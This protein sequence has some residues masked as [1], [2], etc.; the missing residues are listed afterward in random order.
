[1]AAA[2][3]ITEVH[4]RLGPV[5]AALPDLAVVTAAFAVAAAVFGGAARASDGAGRRSRGPLRYPV[6][7]KPFRAPARVVVH[8][9]RPQGF[10]AVL[11]RVVQNFVDR[12]G[13]AGRVLSAVTVHGLRWSVYWLWAALVTCVNW[14]VRWIRHA[15]EIVVEGLK[16]MWQAARQA[17]RT[18]A[19]P[20]AGALVGARLAFLFA[21]N[22]REYLFSGSLAA[23]GM[24]ALYGGA[25]VTALT[26]AWISIGRHRWGQSLRS[27]GR[28]LSIYIANGVLWQAVGGWA[29]G[30]FGTFGPGPIRIGWL[31]WAAT[32][33]LVAT[34]LWSYRKGRHAEST[35][36]QVSGLVP[37]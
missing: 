23:L 7:P 18:V 13:W 34:W 24:F 25:A 21:N 22:V 26:I 3:A 4:D 28:T 32:A 15:A 1:M 6:A 5:L 16:L 27:A 9:L 37:H 8:R 2:D 31:T 17:T 36:P 20:I 30:L 19:V 33:V 11:V 14:L 10:G 35:S 12:A 29:V